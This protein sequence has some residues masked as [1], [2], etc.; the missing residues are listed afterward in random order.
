MVW[1]RFA[2]TSQSST[3]AEYRTF[4]YYHPGADIAQPPSPYYSDDNPLSNHLCLSERNIHLIILMDLIFLLITGMITMM[5][6][7]LIAI[8]CE[9]DYIMQEFMNVFCENLLYYTFILIF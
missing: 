7:Y 9:N 6:L 4:G 1:E 8:Q 3:S 2:C 5:I